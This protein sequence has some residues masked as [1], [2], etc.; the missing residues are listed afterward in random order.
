MD[1]Y[2]LIAMVL[3][4]LMIAAMVVAS[5]YLN[6]QVHIEYTTPSRM[7]LFSSSSDGEDNR[8]A[9]YGKNLVGPT[10]AGGQYRY[11]LLPYR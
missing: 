8:P 2:F 1:R 5:I 4:L 9:E 3:F 11:R 7:F 10:I 6:E